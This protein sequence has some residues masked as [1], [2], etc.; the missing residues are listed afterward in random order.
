MTTR[1]RLLTILS[2]VWM[3]AL[4]TLATVRVFWFGMPDLSAA[5][6]TAYGALMGG[7][8]AAVIGWYKWARRD[9]DAGPDKD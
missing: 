8:L 7:P 4:M 6:A 1:T 5:G 2:V 3:M 9:A